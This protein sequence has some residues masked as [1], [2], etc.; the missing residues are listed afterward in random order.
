MSQHLREKITLT[1]LLR[2][3]PFVHENFFFIFLRGSL[4]SETVVMSEM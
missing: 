4:E 1:E 3:F 2:L